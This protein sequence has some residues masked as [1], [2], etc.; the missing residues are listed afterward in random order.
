[1]KEIISPFVNT[2]LH[3][4]SIRI[5]THPPA[6]YTRIYFTHTHTCTQCEHVSIGGIYSCIFTRCLALL[7]RPSEGSRHLGSMSVQV[8]PAPGKVPHNVL[9]QRLG[10][11]DWIPEVTERGSRPARPR[12]KL[13]LSEGKEISGPPYHR[14]L[15]SPTPVRSVLRQVLIYLC[16]F[17]LGLPI[18]DNRQN[19]RKST[20]EGLLLKCAGGTHFTMYTNK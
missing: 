11:L 4:L 10:L 18:V 13:V 17:P 7:Q 3:S 19:T 16:D 1:M 6:C 5:P 8:C 14:L 2:S 15:P 12:H 9:E 20:V